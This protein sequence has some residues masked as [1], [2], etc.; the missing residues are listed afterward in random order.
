VVSLIVVPQ[1]SLS[2]SEGGTDG[3]RVRG[4]LRNRRQVLIDV[5]HGRDDGADAGCITRKEEG[6]V[7]ENLIVGQVTQFTNTEGKDNV[8]VTPCIT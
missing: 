5:I 2:K 7:F 3:L 1:R 6:T 4:V 8:L